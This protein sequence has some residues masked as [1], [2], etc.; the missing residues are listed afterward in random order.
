MGVVHTFHYSEHDEKWKRVDLLSPLSE[1]VPEVEDYHIPLGNYR[2][3]FGRSL[4]LAPLTDDGTVSL[5]VGAPFTLF[6]REG[7]VEEYYPGGAEFYAYAP[8]NRVFKLDDTL[9]VTV[10]K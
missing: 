10:S 7:E 1:L 6:E 8:P 2:N 3:L 5:M 4:S 9:S